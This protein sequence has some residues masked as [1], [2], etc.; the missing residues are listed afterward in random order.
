MK[1]ELLQQILAY[2]F[3]S[4][5]FNGLPLGGEATEEQKA[6]AIQLTE[7]GLVQVVSDA[8]YPNPHIRPWASKR[9]TEQ[10]VDSIKKLNKESYQLALYPMPVALKAYKKKKR[11]P[12]QPYRQ[13]MG[14]GRGTLE[15]AYFRFDVLER[16]R[17]D[18]KFHFSYWD[19]G[20]STGIGDEAYM[21]DD[22]PVGEK[23]SIQHIGF[24]Y[25]LSGFDPEKPDSPI[26]RRVAAFYGDLADLSPTHQQHWKTYEVKPDG[27]EPHPAWFMSQMGQFPD[28]IGPFEKLF[29]ELENISDLFK[30]A[31]GKPLFKIT[32]RPT[33]FGW[34]LRASQQEWDSFVHELD[35]VLSDNIDHKALTAAGVS[36]KDD[37]GKDNGSLT[38]LEQFLT[39]TGLT[40]ENAKEILKPLRDVRLARQKPAHEL[41]K[42]VTDNTFVHKQ[43]DLLGD[44]NDSLHRL[45]QWL[46]KHP[47]NKD[48][49][50][51]H[52]VQRGY[53]M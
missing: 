36:R 22:E 37:D 3:S 41:R 35:K 11:Y 15:P 26:I 50:P 27:L 32:Q 20:A 40:A 17:N 16:Y 53:R 12:G 52:D 45:R 6:A 28:G 44:V 39:N 33:D 25:D 49:K 47:A 14:K 34:I 42:N 13:E 48:W 46:R 30:R 5:D 8:D 31:F 51:K 10:Q 7:E 38:R 24:A 21:D 1:D 9:T 43:I 2:Y 4:R 23:T 19:F 29:S 18:P